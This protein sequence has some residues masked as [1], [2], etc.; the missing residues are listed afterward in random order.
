MRRFF[1]GPEAFEKGIVTLT[2]DEAKHLR[3][4]LRLR[5]GAEVLVFD[6]AGK[7][8][9]CIVKDVRRD[10]TE[11]E[12]VAEVEPTKPESPLKLTMAVALLKGEKFE[13]VIQKGTELGVTEFI[14][15][16]T[17]FADVQLRDERDITK[18]LT[19]WQRIALEAAKQ[20]G[21]A[22]VPEVKK[23]V[24][25]NL[26][27][28]ETGESSSR[29]MFTEREGESLSNETLSDEIVALIGSEGGWSDEELKRARDARWKLVTLGGRI[30]RAETA[31]IAIATLLQHL[32]GDLK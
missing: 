9:R 15:V 27:I 30:L 13:L 25:F 7:E 2:A 21:R 4:V 17:R 6:G 28:N 31:G 19:R 1:A 3:E 12:L 26:L 11:L 22:V 16:A 5:P 14:P 20:C 24:A 29:L 32:A 10:F 18:R 23:P 8:F